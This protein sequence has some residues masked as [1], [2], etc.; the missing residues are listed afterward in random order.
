M[1]GAL[2]PATPGA[3]CRAEASRL[4]RILSGQ[5]A[6]IALAIVVGAIHD[7]GFDWGDAAIGA[8]GALLVAAGAGAGL[9]ARLLKPR[10]AH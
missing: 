8:A 3:P 6:L 9:S 2:T 5:T 10:G 4:R 1:A 7:D